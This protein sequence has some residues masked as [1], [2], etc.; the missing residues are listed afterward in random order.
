MELSIAKIDAEEQAATRM[1]NFRGVLMI[2]QGAIEA[3]QIMIGDAFLPVLTKLAEKANELV[4]AYGPTVTKAFQDFGA[5]F[6]NLFC[7]SRSRHAADDRLL[8]C[9]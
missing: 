9:A 6:N 7:R 4:S 1:K 2:L 3:V 5:S 8:Y